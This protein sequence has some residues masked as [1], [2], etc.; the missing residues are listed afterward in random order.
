MELI[1]RA[2]I[3]VFIFI[4]SSANSAFAY[5]DAGS[6]SMIMQILLG[7]LAGIAVIL[8]LFWRRILAIFGINR[9]KKEDEKIIP[10]Q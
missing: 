10:P 8:K 7:G 6:G 1:L 5:L 3:I 2:T 9:Q 4:L